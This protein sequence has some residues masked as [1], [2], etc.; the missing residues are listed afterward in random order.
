MRPWG[1]TVKKG[2]NVI[3]NLSICFINLYS[4]RIARRNGG[5]YPV[6][7]QRNRSLFLLKKSLHHRPVR[8][9]LQNLEREIRMNRF[10]TKLEMASSMRTGGSYALTEKTG[11]LI[12]M[13]K[14]QE[15]TSIIIKFFREVRY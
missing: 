10:F 4:K 15:L 14:P 1:L 13:E 8:L 9:G 11:H 7:H 2:Y 5:L 12:P 6:D 3:T